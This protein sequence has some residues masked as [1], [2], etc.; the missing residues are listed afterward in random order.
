MKKIAFGL[1]IIVSSSA[2]ANYDLAFNGKTVTCYGEDNRTFILN[3]KR[4]TLK[5]VAEGESS[6][7]KK[8]KATKSD[9]ATYVS[10]TSS[11]GRLTLSDE[12]DTFEFSGPGHKP[13][14]TQAESVDCK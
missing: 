6:G 10:Y 4:T 8:I 2:M 3:A 13:D 1:L 12:G 11:E 5:Y 14:G 7:A 9:D